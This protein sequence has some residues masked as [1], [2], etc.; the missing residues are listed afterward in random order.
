MRRPKIIVWRLGGILLAAAALLA[1]CND[2][3][4]VR[5]VVAM[6]GVNMNV[7]DPTES[8]RA[9]LVSGQYG[10]AVE[11]LGRLVQQEPGNARAMTLLAVAYD[12]LHRTDLAD[13]YYGAALAADPHFVAALNNWGYSHL[14]RRD[15]AEAARLLRLAAEVKGHGPIV[16]ANLRLLSGTSEGPPSQAA[17]PVSQPAPRMVPIAAHVTA[18]TR[19]V[20]LVRM[21][22]GVQLLVTRP[23]PAVAA[24]TGG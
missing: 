15:Y 4:G 13:R 22:P 1:G 5:P 2:D 6:A 10:L 24:A 14:L 7:Q 8:G 19:V 20:P 21:A 18:D 23:A 17:E 9:F 3:Y 12:R 11:K 16:E